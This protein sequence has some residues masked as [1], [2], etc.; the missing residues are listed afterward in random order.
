[1]NHKPFFI[2][3]Y[4]PQYYKYLNCFLNWFNNLPAR[5]SCPSVGRNGYEKS[6]PQCPNKNAPT[7][8]FRKPN[9]SCDG[10][11]AGLWQ[12]ERWISG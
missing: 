11:G 10:P 5:F 1:M 4:N 9:R 8:Y 3:L 7:V 12:R 6:Q 2:G